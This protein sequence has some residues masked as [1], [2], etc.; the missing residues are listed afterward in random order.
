[1]YPS[2]E[3]FSM[4]DMAKPKSKVNVFLILAIIFGLISAALAIALILQLVEK[5][6]LRDEN[7]DLKTQISVLTEKKTG[8]VKKVLKGSPSAQNVELDD[9]GLASEETGTVTVIDSS[10]YLEPEGWAVRF[11]YPEGVTDIA[12]AT[13]PSYDGAI[14][15]TGIAKD[16]KVYDVNI[17]GGKEKYNQYPFFLGSA[18]KWNTAGN[19][20]EWDTSPATYDG[21]KKIAKVGTNEYFVDTAYGS[22]CEIGENADYIEATKLVKELFDGFEKKQ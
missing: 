1:M 8:V 10:K 13:S 14:Y 6:K 18:Y 12:Y 2:N 21:V 3:N 15:I 7:S 4:N 11:K 22:G 16:A 19:H 9:K 20:E 5:S 17:C